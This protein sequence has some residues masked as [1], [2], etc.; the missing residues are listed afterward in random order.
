MQ[1][2]HYTCIIYRAIWG[3]ALKLFCRIR[4]FHGIKPLGAKVDGKDVIVS[5]TSY[6]Q[7]INS[8][9]PYT[10]YSLFHQS[11]MPS[12][13]V[14]VID[15]Y[16][17][18]RIGNELD[19]FMSMGLEIL[20]DNR[21]LRSYKKLIPTIEKYPN[22]III[23]VDDDVYY[24]K[25]FIENMLNSY[26]VDKTCIHANM[27]HQITF[28]SEGHL[29]DYQKW[30]DADFVKKLQIEMGFAVGVGGI[31]YQRNLLHEDLT[32]V[33]L[34]KKLCPRADDIWFF[35]MAKLVKTK[36]REVRAQKN[37]FVPLDFFYQYTHKEAS[38]SASNR[39]ENMNDVQIKNVL[40]FYHITMNVLLFQ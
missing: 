38:L 20:F 32:N 14:L 3:E 31:L 19:Y 21:D 33:E 24:R 35:V 4:R 6:G 34:F 18:N 37:Y 26:S 40:E 9:L 10:I 15:N 29:N 36:Y 16:E 22:D 28:D 30:I 13:I 25:Y 39:D 8:T 1:L 27:L 17:Q 2:L 23:T 12:R 7:R 5:L 11:V